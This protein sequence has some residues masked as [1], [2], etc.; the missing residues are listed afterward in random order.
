MKEYKIV[1]YDAKPYDRV[2]FEKISHDDITYKFLDIKLNSDTMLLAKGSDA[3][4]VFVNDSI[5][6]E[7]I[8]GL[9][10]MGI[11]LLLMRCA[12]YNNVD[13]KH[14]YKKLH[15]LNVPSYSPY[16]VAEHAMALILTLNRKTHKAYARVR[17]SNFS[18]NGL[19]GM[20]LKNKTVGIIGT[21]RIGRAFIDI[22]RGFGMNILAYD[23]YPGEIL[24]V[25]YV[26]LDELYRKSDLI[27]LHCPLTGDTHHMINGESI[28]IMK[29]GVIII[30][31]SRGGLIDTMAL[32]EGLKDK[33]IG[34][35]ALD[36]YEE[37]MDYFFEDF[38]Q[39]IISDDVL[40]R[41]L[42]FPNVLI[43]SHQAFLTNEAL[44]NIAQT[45]LSNFNE[46]IKGDEL[47][48]EICYHC[49]TDKKDCIRKEKGRCF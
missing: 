27:S 21:G 49:S 9:S 14:A 43:T 30:N 46:F 38:S 35:A 47:T 5:D 29:T 39:E 8:E 44:E 22:C 20:D 34:G 37:E 11:K 33:K 7:V 32:T 4:C 12:G 48:H 23:K 31:T 25:K 1:F 28:K 26:G 42:T 16:S 45:T 15:I 10:G 19:T 24:D 41:L 13:I 17:N 18:I 36:V 40:A 6:K 2:S 3:V